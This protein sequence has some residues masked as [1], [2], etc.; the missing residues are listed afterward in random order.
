[1]SVPPISELIAALKWLEGVDFAN[2]PVDLLP[3]DR[4]AKID[5]LS[6]DLRH[7]KLDPNL[8]EPFSARMIRLVPDAWSEPL[9]DIGSDTKNTRFNFMNSG[10][11][12]KCRVLYFGYPQV[13]AYLE[14][15]QDRNIFEDPAF[16]PIPHTSFTYQIAIPN[17]LRL[18]DEAYA[19][20]IGISLGALMS[21]WKYMNDDYELPSVSQ[22]VA[23]I[24]Q[25]SRYKGILYRSA[26]F[27]AGQNLVIFTNNTP[28]RF[29]SLVEKL[30]LN[31]QDLNQRLLGGSSS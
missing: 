23:Y 21:D 12:I 4:K 31:W 9:S 20:R 15:F 29:A 28:D 19:K 6:A 10:E 3:E 13:T 1:M 16:A 8:G 26:R 22:L 7:L 5:G 11:H 30:P 18:D 27:G 2:L 25:Q 14:R 24:S 17:I